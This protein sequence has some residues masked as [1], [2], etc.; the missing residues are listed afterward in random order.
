[1]VRRS[2]N[3]AV[4]ILRLKSLTLIKSVSSN[5]G[6]SSQLLLVSLFSFLFHPSVLQLA[7]MIEEEKKLGNDFKNARGVDK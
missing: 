3:S 1:M 6:M 4:A 7:S 2:R 5:F